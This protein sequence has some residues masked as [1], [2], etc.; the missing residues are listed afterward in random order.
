[1]TKIVQARRRVKDK[2]PVPFSKRSYSHDLESLSELYDIWNSETE[3]PDTL[4]IRELKTFLTALRNADRYKGKTVVRLIQ[5]L[6]VA[7][8]DYD[9]TSGTYIASP[10]QEW[11][12]RKEIL[13][14]MGSINNNIKQLISD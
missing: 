8:I 12:R 5:D 11:E 1:M 6:I 7:I 10:M 14:Q 9:E 4:R 3:Q 13:S 2:N